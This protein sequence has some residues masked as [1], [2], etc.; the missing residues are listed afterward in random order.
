MEIQALKEKLRD[1][2]HVIDTMNCGLVAQDHEGVLRFANQKI[3]EWLGYERDE[4][5]GRPIVDLV[6][7]ELRA[8]LTEELGDV[9]GGDLRARLIAL[10]RKDSTTFPVLTIPQRFVEANGKPDGYFAIVVDLGT[11]FTARQMGPAEPI[12]VRSTLQRIAM[13]LQSLSLAAPTGAAAALP[14]NR[15]ELGELSPREVEVLSL[16]VASDRVATIAERLHISQHTVRNH[17][18]S[19]YRKLGVGNQTELI[20]HVRT[21]GADVPE[22]TPGAPE[23]GSI[24]ASG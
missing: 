23:S 10:L 16:L 12:D 2:E 1:Y 17:M 20:E 5:L 11:V 22:A 7:E 6:P 15:P 19:M 3:L 4:I 21:L 9:E 14:L 18:K 13:E 24:D 8:F